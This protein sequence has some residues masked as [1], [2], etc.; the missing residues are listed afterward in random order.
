MT[1]RELASRLA[2]LLEEEGI[3][4]IP[5]VTFPIAWLGI[6]GAS[7]HIFIGSVGTKIGFRKHL[8]GGTIY[9]SRK[10]R[11]DYSEIPSSFQDA[12]YYK[13]VQ[14]LIERILGKR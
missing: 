5:S 6:E 11:A 2:F 13:K 12:F 7:L 1:R 3:K 8:A 4:L 14:T 9:I 10:G